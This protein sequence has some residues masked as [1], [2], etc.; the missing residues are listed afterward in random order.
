MLRRAGLGVALVALALAGCAGGPAVEYKYHVAV[1]PK[2]LT[3]EFWKSIHAG[4]DRAAADLKEQK[5]IAVEVQFQG[6]AKESDTQEQGNIL[7]RMLAQNVNG[8]VLAPQHSKTMV[9]KVESAVKKGVPVVIIDSGLDDP[10]LYVKYVATDNYHGGR[11][12]AERL[13]EVLAAKKKK[14]VKL[15]LLRYAPGSES[16]EQR[17]KGFLDVIEEQEKA[18]KFNVTWLSKD[19]YAGATVDTAQKAATQ[20]LNNERGKGIDGIFAPNE[21]SATGTLNAMRSLGLDP[22]TRLVGFDASD[23]LRDALRKGDYLDGLV[24]Q[25]PYKMG[26]LG[27]WTLVH[28]LEGYDV[29]PG[30]NKVQST[31]EHVVTRDNLDADS[32]KE[33]FVAEMQAGRKIDAPK[34][35]KK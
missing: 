12:A 35:E 26:Y 8:L 1:I 9:P 29:A 23:P 17:E 24:V 16:T 25:D 20:V 7:D 32:T 6:P 3:H 30:G 14:D 27:V 33:L 18:G 31:G 13:L 10:K 5:G 34:F 22:D 21:S 15:I 4:A 19:E 11:L 2:G 28:H